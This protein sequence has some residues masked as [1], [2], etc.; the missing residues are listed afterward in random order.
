MHH[1]YD[2]SSK[3]LIQH[4]GDS[5]LR[6]A[7]VRDFLTWRP[8]AAELVRA[9][10]R[11]QFVLNHGGLHIPFGQA[12]LTAWAAGLRDLARSDNVTVKTSGFD[13][14]DPT[15]RMTVIVPCGVC[16]RPGPVARYACSS[17]AAV[18]AAPGSANS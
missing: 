9:T 5:I 2:K 3:W 12:D 4:Y 17:A 8:L 1:Q 11:V 18:A 16:T 10:P 14:V 6:L 13:T 15:W 7:G